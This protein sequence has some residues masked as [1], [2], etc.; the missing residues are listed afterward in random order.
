M[1]ID[2]ENVLSKQIQDSFHS[3]DRRLPAYKEILPFFK[4]LFVLQEEAIPNTRPDAI[5]NTTELIEAKLDGGFPLMDRQDVPMDL[6]AAISLLKALLVEAEEANR[7]MR[8]AAA[9]INTIMQSDGDDIEHGFDL[10]MTGDQEGVKRLGEK[11]GIDQEML[12]FFL[13]NSLFPSIAH[14]TRQLAEQH[15]I[16]ANWGKGSC[17]IC[18]GLPNLSYLSEGGQ[19]FL[20]CHFCRHQ[21]PIRR[22]LCPHCGVS[23]ADEVGYLFVEEEKAYRIYTCDAC[24]AYIKTVDTRELSHAFYPPLE[25]I[26][27][28]H[29]DLHALD[30]GYQ[31]KIHG[32]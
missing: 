11:I 24:H 25:N 19:R 7:K 12:T 10:V 8:E 32:V 6:P 16:N 30:M 17:P 21:W 27:T 2:S 13:Y 3:A 28:T 1:T 5:P 14:H 23:D 20:I 15:D 18:G 29:L 26:I 4:N 31:S 9:T 22:I